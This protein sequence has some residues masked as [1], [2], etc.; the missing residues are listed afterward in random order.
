MKQASG[1]GGSMTDWATC[2]M[3]PSAWPQLIQST[4]VWYLHVIKGGPVTELG[5]SS[6]EVPRGRPG[7]VTCPPA[8]GWQH[9]RA[10]GRSLQDWSWERST[11]GHIPTGHRALCRVAVSRA[12]EARPNLIIPAAQVFP[13]AP[14]SHCILFAA[15]LTVPRVLTT[16]AYR[17]LAREPSVSSLDVLL[18]LRSPPPSHD[19]FPAPLRIPWLSCWTLFC[20][21]SKLLG[22]W[23]YCHKY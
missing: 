7:A 5:G 6:W 3:W 20:S 8:S 15:L 1:L 13:C 9:M 4:C 17:A 11:R 12:L 22:W 14:Y 16:T 2:S 18:L 10:E 23:T 19:S 21:I